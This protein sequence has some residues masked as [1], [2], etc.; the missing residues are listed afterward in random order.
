MPLRS[1]HD[2]VALY[3]PVPG[4][5]V[6]S[7]EPHEPGQAALRRPHREKKRSRFSSA[8]TVTL[9]S[10]NHGPTLVQ[11]FPLPAFPIEGNCLYFGHHG[12][13]NSQSGQ[14]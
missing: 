1:G 11:E 14:T 6:D 12:A 5:Q 9:S 7:A 3:G 4:M 13:R 8:R 2:A 10:V